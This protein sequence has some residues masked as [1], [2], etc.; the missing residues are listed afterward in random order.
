MWLIL[1]A[2]GPRKRTY[3][4]NIIIRSWQRACV[5]VSTTASVLVKC[6]VN[7]VWYVWSLTTTYS[8]T[9]AE[10]ESDSEAFLKKTKDH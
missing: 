7:S 3:N 6:L 10:P 4:N 2:A 8:R 5:S 9:H 1:P